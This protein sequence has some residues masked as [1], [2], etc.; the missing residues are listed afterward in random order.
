M[1]EDDA[2]YA[3]LLDVD[4]DAGDLAD[5]ALLDPGSDGLCTA[6]R[7]KLLQELARRREAG[8]SLAELR[9]SAG[10]VDPWSVTNKVLEAAVDQGARLNSFDATGRIPDQLYKRR[11]RGINVCPCPVC[12]RRV[13]QRALRRAG[14]ALCTEGDPPAGTGGRPTSAFGG[15]QA[16]GGR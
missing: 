1:L 8:A 14:C 10:Q 9:R 6:P 11:F 4:A 7:H 13:L 5:S 2:P 12:G 15:G 16:S 3:E